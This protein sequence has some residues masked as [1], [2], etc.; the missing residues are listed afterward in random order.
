VHV[1]LQPGQEQQERQADQREHL[2][3]RVH[4]DPG[5]HRRAEHDPGNDLQHRRGH[6]H[7]GHLP[8][9]QRRQEGHQRDDQ[10]VR[11]GHGVSLG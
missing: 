10:Q 1:D 2:D 5:E 9:G 4:L 6:T 7:D 11:E 3:R 8:H